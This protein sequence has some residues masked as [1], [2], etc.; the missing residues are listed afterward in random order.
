MSS[1]A[2]LKMMPLALADLMKSQTELVD[3]DRLVEAAPHY[4]ELSNFPECEAKRV[5]ERLYRKLAA[6]NK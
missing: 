2:L 4:Y 1:T 6:S 3:A 5:I